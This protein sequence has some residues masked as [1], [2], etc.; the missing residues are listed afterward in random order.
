[1]K[2]KKWKRVTD[3]KMRW[4]GDIDYDK[5]IIRV[6]KAKKKNKKKG[7]ISNTIVHEEIHRQHPQMHEK[8]VAKKAN[9]ATPA[10]KQK[11]QVL[12]RS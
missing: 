8:T 1:M 11:Y 2:N 12:Y 10:Q 4:H 7:E 3:N 6:N 9:Q 5:K